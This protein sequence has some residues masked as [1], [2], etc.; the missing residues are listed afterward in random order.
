MK[1]NTLLRQAVADRLRAELD[2]DL[3]NQVFDTWLIIEPSEM[4]AVIVHHDDGELNDEYLDRGERY[5]CQFN[6]S[7]YL[8]GT[9]S[10]ADLDD[11]AEAI[12]A[13]IPQ[14]YRFAGLGQV[15]RTGF[16][17]ERSESGAYRAL[18][19]IHQFKA[20]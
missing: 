17:Y 19:L 7:I 3:V 11:L 4:P 16:Q 14:G 20:E 15:F 2:P 1:E 13:I 10:D 5:N 18:H 9:R 12:K 8:E 6:C